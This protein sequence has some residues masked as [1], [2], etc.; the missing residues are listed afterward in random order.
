MSPRPKMNDESPKDY[1]RLYSEE[2]T[3]QLPAPQQQ[4][5]PKNFCMDGAPRALLYK[6]VDLRQV[7]L[8]L[9]NLPEVRDDAEKV[10]SNHYNAFVERKQSSFRVVIKYPPTREE[11]YVIKVNENTLKA[12]EAKLP[13]KGRYRFFFKVPGSGN[14]LEEIE[15]PDAR[16]PIFNERDGIKQ[17]HLHLF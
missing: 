3:Q 1:S 16:V 12:I 8:K 4:Q 14:C 11:I 6:E 10:L 2:R 13:I 9:K 17:I 7:V 5:V 15:S